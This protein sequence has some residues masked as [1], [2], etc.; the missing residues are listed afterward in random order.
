M[1]LPYQEYPIFSQSQ[2][3]KICKNSPVNPPEIIIL[4]SKVF[5]AREL[6]DDNLPA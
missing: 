5:A 1:T 6:G 4:A 3:S 2:I